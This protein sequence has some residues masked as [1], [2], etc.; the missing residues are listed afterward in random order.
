MSAADFRARQQERR[1]ATCQHF[2][3]I[4]SKCC[5][6]GIPYSS[7]RGSAPYSL[8]CLRDDHWHAGGRPPCAEYIA[9]TREQVDAEDAEFK[10]RIEL[11][12]KG[13]SG[14][15]EAA[16]NTRQVITSGRHK[17]HGPR[18]CSKCG[19]IAFLV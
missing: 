17:G 13:L 8:S 2:T 6:A 9:Q 18:F 7:V 1:R 3:G 12:A 5:K 16:L 4:Q 14:C 15:C 19:A 11:H 10:R